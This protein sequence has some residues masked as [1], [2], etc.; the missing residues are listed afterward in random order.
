MERSTHEVI[1]LLEALMTDRLVRYCTPA[2]ESNW[3]WDRSNQV[4]VL[5]P[6][7]GVE[8]TASEGR[9]RCQE[10]LAVCLLPMPPKLSRRL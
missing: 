5:Q 7:I 4:R 2:S 9:G 3:L 10:L 6:P 1:L 8:Y